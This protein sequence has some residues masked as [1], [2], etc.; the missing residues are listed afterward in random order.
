MKRFYTLVLSQRDQDN[1][2]HRILLDGRPVK[3]PGK[4][5]LAVPSDAL[6]AA[7]VSEWAGQGEKIDPAT[8]PI[9]GFANA[10]IDQ[11]LPDVATFAKGI[12]AYG[13]NDLLCYRASDPN[14]LVAE[15]AQLWDPLLDWARDRYDVAFV[16]TSGIMP[17][18]QPAAT[19]E[20]LY[21]AVDAL[22]PWLLSGFSTLVSIS[23]SLLGSLALVEGVITADALWAAA[24][25]DEAW[26]ARQW[27]EDAEAI[28][29]NAIRRGQYDDAAR[30]CALVAGAS[31]SPA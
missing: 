14:E 25:V 28:A 17:V 22:D 30:Y 15:Q 21:A 4:E 5:P 16:V 31:D 26:Q 3:T 2:L 9:M 29:R 20:R 8:M 27:G 19:V 24:H 1:G 11:V 18:D 13:A 12:A 6:A 10:S 7:I 23:G